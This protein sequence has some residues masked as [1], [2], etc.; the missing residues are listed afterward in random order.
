MLRD[1]WNRFVFFAFVT[2]TGVT[3]KTATAITW[4]IH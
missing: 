1:N 4:L 3:T 2:E